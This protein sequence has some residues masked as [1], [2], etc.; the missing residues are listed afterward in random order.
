VPIDIAS[1][2][3]WEG[4]AR[5]SPLAALAIASTMVRRRMRVRFVKLILWAF[6]LVPSVIGGLVFYFTLQGTGPISERQLEE[7]GLKDVNLLAVLNQFFDKIVGFWA[8]LLAALVGAPLI[9]EDRRAHALPLYFSRPIGH[10]EYVVGKAASAA[11]FLAMLLVLPRI[12]MYGVEVAFSE[13]EGVARG[14]LPTLLRS[15]AT[16]ALGVGVLT[17]IALGVSSLTERPT[18]A[19]L[20]LLGIGA[21]TSGLAFHLSGAL[22]DATWLAISPTACI[23]RI[24]MDLIEVPAQLRTDLRYLEKLAVREA[25]IGAGA[26]A[27]LGLGILVV[28]VRRVEVVT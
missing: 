13:A 17:S 21:V 26:W 10:I 25:W 18:Y 20:F 27:G 9:A 24:G 14:Q 16:G 28:R 6:T 19:A 23:Q 4:R 15:C 8:M 11:F 7:L 5:P 22:R 12:C 1:Y 3:R 2:R